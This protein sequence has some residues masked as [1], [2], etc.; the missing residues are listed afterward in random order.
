MGGIFPRF[1]WQAY[2]RRVADHLTGPDVS[3][4][5]IFYS[6][7]FIVGSVASIVALE[8]TARD[9]LF[10]PVVDPQRIRRHRRA[11]WLG[12]LANVGATLL[13]MVL[14]M[15]AIALIFGVRVAW[16]RLPYELSPAVAEPRA[17]LSR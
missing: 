17:D 12:L 6:G 10:L 2:E 5:V 1:S 13:A 9:H 14:P 11:L 7:V 8:V 16:L 4:A 15:I 3:T